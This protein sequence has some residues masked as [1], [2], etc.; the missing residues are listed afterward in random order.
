MYFQWSC[1]L[2]SPKLNIILS[3]QS[4]VNKIGLYEPQ[5]PQQNYISYLFMHIFHTSQSFPTYVHFITLQKFIFYSLFPIIY[6]VSLWGHVF[7]GPGASCDVVI[8]EVFQE[9]TYFP[10]LECNG[11]VKEPTIKH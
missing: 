1:P 11:F 6:N 3:A 9:I 10:A 2:K 8:S 5:Q 7:L 4:F